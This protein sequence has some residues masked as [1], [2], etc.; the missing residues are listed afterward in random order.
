MTRKSAQAQARKAAAKTS[1][2]QALQAKV[3]QALGYHKAGA[4]AFAELLYGDVLAAQPGHAQALHG[5]GVLTGQKGE[6]LR[7]IELIDRAIRLAPNDP[8]F[9]A[10]RALLLKDLLR[11][12]EALAGLDRA[13]ALKPDYAHAQYNRA[14]LLLLT[15]DLGRGWALQEWRFKS[16]RTPRA[17]AQPC[18]LGEV[19]L[20][21]KTLLLHA[22]QGLG[23]AIQFCR[24]ATLAAQRGARVLLEVPAPLVE[25]LRTLDGAPEVIAAGAPLPAF[26]LHCPL[27]SLPLAFDTDAA[28]IPG[29]LG[30]LKSE[31][32]KVAHWSARLGPRTRPRV[33]LA[34][35]GST[36]YPGDARRSIALAQWL[37]SLRPDIEYVSL[38]KD[39]RDADA[40]T[41]QAHGGIRHFG[42][43]QGD[44][45]DAAALAELMDVVVS[46]DTSLAHLAAAL[47]RPTWVLLGQVPDWRWQLERRD[48][49]WYPTVRLFRQRS[50]GDWAGVLADVSADLGQL[51]A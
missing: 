18:W 14:M 1:P 41:L 37:P 48:S 2:A 51:S 46:V 38:H 44:F 39:L 49:P 19:P 42:S 9:H 25:L 4:F 32:A 20:A 13:I 23:D 30:Y 21:G 7:G 31:P 12:D 8:T 33:G 27:P 15:G 28:S 29:P 35:S 6:P 3:D 34:W 11:F 47:G 16:T 36:L 40:T 43:E 24:Y 17:L 50:A 22:E 45:T 10:N 26:D 5:L